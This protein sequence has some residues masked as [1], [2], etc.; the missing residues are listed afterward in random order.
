MLRLLSVLWF[1]LLLS[2]SETGL[3]QPPTTAASN[4]AFS[5]VYCQQLRISWTSGNGSNR[6]VVA[7]QGSNIN[8]YPS[9]NAI[10]YA[11]DTF[12]RGE[13]IG[14]LNY[15]VYRRLRVAVET[16]MRLVARRGRME[17]G[18]GT[19]D[20]QLMITVNV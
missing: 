12:G 7:R 15:V 9:D 13:Q 1:L 10:Y 16:V 20:D 11:S 5:N 19:R 2:L 14:S 4:L 18:T 8:V 3:A 17:S 6:I